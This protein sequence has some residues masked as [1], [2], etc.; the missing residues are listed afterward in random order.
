MKWLAILLAVGLAVWAVMAFA[1]PTYTHRYRLT[2]EVDTP[3]GV[4]SGS[5]VIEVERSDQ[6]WVLIAQ[7]RYVFDVRGEAVFVDLGDGRN[8]IA[9]MAFGPRAEN[10]D[11]MISLWVEAYGHYKWDEDAWSG[12][13]KMQGPI[14][15]KPPL[16]PTLVTF[17]DLSDPKTAR[18]VYATG[19]IVRDQILSNGRQPRIVGQG[20]LFDELGNV[21]G[22]GYRFRRATIQ[23][24]SAGAWPLNIFGLSGEPITHA[25]EGR[26]VG[27]RDM[28]RWDEQLRRDSYDPSRLRVGSGTLK[29]EGWSISNDLFLAIL[30]RLQPRVQ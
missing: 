12:R 20:V 22:P 18:V 30:A 14:E 11:Q 23:M 13:T 29:K 19:A 9:L 2:I 17:S 27:L 24:V 6:R 25:I 28:K 1:F 3:Q 10:V 4:R 7:G 26:V 21:F 8:L 16:I 5:S 15:L